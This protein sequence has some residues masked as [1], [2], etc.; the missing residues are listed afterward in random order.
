M[1]LRKGLRGVWKP[2]LRVTVA[3]LLLTAASGKAATTGS[4]TANASGLWSNSANWS[5]GTIPGTAAGDTANI[6]FNITTNVAVTIDS[7][8]ILG[9]LNIGDGTTQSNS[10]TV[11]TSGAATLTF[12]NGASAAALTQSTTS[13]GDTISATTVLNS[14]LTITNSNVTKTLTLS[15]GITAGTSGTKAITISGS[16]VGSVL[17]SGNIGTGS[18]D[19][20]IVKNNGNNT[21]TLSGTNT[22]T[23]GVTL[24]SG[25]L[26]LG[27]TTA[28]GAS[29][30][31]L[32]IAGGTLTGNTAIANANA[33]KWN[34]NFSF[35]G[36]TNLDLGAGAVTM[37]AN[38]TVTVSGS[39]TYSVG[40]PIGQSGSNFALTVAN[41]PTNQITGKLVLNG[42]NTYSGGTNVNGGVVQFGSV[43]AI[44]T[45]GNIVVG[46]GGALAVAGAYTTLA[47][48]LSETHLSTSS[49]GALAL[50]ADSSENFDSGAAGY[51]SISMGA[52]VGT[53]VN[54]TGTITPASGVYRVGGGGGTLNLT[55]ANTITG[56]NALVTGNGGGGL[57]VIAASNDYTGTTTVAS[58]TLQIGNGGTTGSID[59]TSNIVANGTLAFNHSDTVTFSKAVSGTGGIAQ[60]GTGVLIINGTSNTYATTS[61]NRSVL[62]LGAT[63]ALPIASTLNIGSGSTAGTFDMSTFSQ[64]LGSLN[65]LSTSSAVTNTITIGSGQT[66]TVNGAF[67]VGVP[68]QSGIT[69]KATITGGAL[70]VNNTAANF[71]VGLANAD[72]NT[73]QNVASL[74]ITGVSSFSANVNEFRVG[75]GSQIGSTLKLSNTTNTITANTV[76]VSNSI[77]NN[78]QACFLTLGTGTNFISADTINLGVSKGVATL[79]FASQTAG[80]PGTVVIGGKT[81]ATADFVLANSAGSSTGATPTATLDLRGH[82]STVTA[83]TVTVASRD[84]GTGGALGTINFDTGTF[85]VNSLTLATKT[86]TSAASTATGILNLSGGAFTVNSGG[87]FT[88]ATQSGAGT[89]VG[90]LNITGGVFTSNVDILDGGGTTT[91][92]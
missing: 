60:S 79:S 42:A 69:T 17:I 32:T 58:G 51:N 75:Y 46:S 48:W 7:T 14:A 27:S 38:R 9:T 54:Y 72:Q 63:N 5:L 84:T 35:G 53:T 80:S 90:T 8:R 26:N 83:G 1:S 4:W 28:L 11:A 92:T 6:N 44:P 67:N 25:I 23:G 64:T 66:L 13:N 78:A 76:Q 49:T 37:N 87:S 43:S 85:T 20:S 45:T 91:T 61:I 56:G 41:G 40:G 74:D 68:N 3:S 39:G 82:N 31:I 86:T 70:V 21:L 81:K 59:S 50:T 19:V 12:D 73:S 47:G 10:Y 18:G 65:F 77:N 2:I 62:R 30:S 34:G 36:T 16:A 52:A 15:G 24:N 71:E 88:L 29:G 57:V 33:Q 89:A 22:F 55:T